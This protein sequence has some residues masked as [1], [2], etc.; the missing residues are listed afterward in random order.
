MNTCLNLPLLL[1]LL[2]VLP[3]LIKE[4]MSRRTVCQNLRF[5]WSKHTA[6]LTHSQENEET[7]HIEKLE[8]HNIIVS[9]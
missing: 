7:A 6:S 9:R 5:T 8:I 4:E 2:P 3:P 1:L